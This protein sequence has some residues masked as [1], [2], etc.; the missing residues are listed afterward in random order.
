MG[1]GLADEGV[2]VRHSAAMKIKKPV[3]RE[4]A[5]HLALI[6]VPYMMGD[7]RQGKGPVSCRPVRK[8]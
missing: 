3:D 2:G 1:D 5:M 6:Q 4:E 7:E 8:S